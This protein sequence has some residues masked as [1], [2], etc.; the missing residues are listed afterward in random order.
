MITLSHYSIF[1]LLTN[2]KD[3][4]LYFEN[5]NFEHIK[6]TND[7]YCGGAISFSSE[8]NQNQKTK[9]TIKGCLFND[10]T[11][12]NGG[13]AVYFNAPTKE[14]FVENTKFINTYSNNDK[15]QKGHFI[16]I[17]IEF[18]HHF[19]KIGLILHN[20]V[21]FQEDSMPI[22]IKCPSTGGQFFY[23]KFINKIDDFTIES[24][25]GDS[26]IG[27]VSKN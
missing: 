7:K 1:Q 12:P 3:H 17:G 22:T 20:Y 2:D 11:S 5:T 14:L 16:V 10:V 18:L 23:F 24:C 6:F 9:I 19:E 8:V 21:K 26:T 13:G 27:K 4:E 15:D 25:I